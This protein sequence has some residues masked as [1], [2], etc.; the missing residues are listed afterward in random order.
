MNVPWPDWWTPYVSAFVQRV[1]ALPGPF[2]V[3]SWGRTVSH[4]RAVG[5]AEQSQHLVWTAAD[6]VPQGAM[7]MAELHDAAVASGNFGYVLDEGDHVHVQL[8]RG[9]VL[10]PQLFRDVAV[11]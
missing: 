9:G 11:A 6:L 2:T 3:S 1:R 7:S 8:Y 4:N 5:G 10:P